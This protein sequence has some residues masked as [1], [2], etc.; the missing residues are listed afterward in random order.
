MRVDRFHLGWFLQGSAIQSWGE[1]WTGRIADEWMVPDL[2]IDLARALERACFD[3]ILIE[4]STYIGE[5]YGNSR[6]IYLKYAMSVP[7]QD[8][9]VLA[10]MMLQQTSRL[11]VVATFGTFGYHPYALARLVGTLD[12]VSS[13]RAGWNVVTGSSDLAAQ[14]FGNERLPE[15]DLRYDMADEY[16]EVVKQLWQSWEPGAIIA[17][18]ESGILV[19][20]NKVHTIDFAGRYYKSRGPLNSG[21]CPQGRP[22]I[23]QAG[24]SL[25][26]RAYA[27]KHADTVVAHVTDLDGMKQYLGSVRE[28]A[29]SH[30]RDPATCK[31]LFLVSPILADTAEEAR[32]RSRDMAARA[33]ERLDIQLARIAKITNIDFS[34][35]D[36]DQPLGSLTT[37]GHQQSLADFLRKAGKR[38]LREAVATYNT[39]GLSIDL[40]GTPEQVAGQMEEVMQEVGGDGFLFTLGN[41]TRRTIA[42]ITDGLVPALQQRGLVRTCYQHK[43]LRDTLLEF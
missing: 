23:A 30:G 37:N 39:T 14:N 34:Q 6:E 1:A 5:A 21:P 7:K 43:Q 3:Y 27:A 4:D 16:I 31:V 2:F 17:D 12:Q 10:S 20:H 24:G 35:L 36:L 42:E 11:G 40:I 41:T 33:A 22:V 13:G 9:A 29:R 32:Q 28:M 19:D 15:H 25:K 18:R 26:G 38:T 8:P